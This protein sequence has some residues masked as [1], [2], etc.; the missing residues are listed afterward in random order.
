MG[1]NRVKIE[2]VKHGTGSLQLVKYLLLL[3]TM[4]YSALSVSTI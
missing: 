3:T 4:I 2:S 1:M